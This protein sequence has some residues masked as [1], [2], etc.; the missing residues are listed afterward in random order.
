MQH[1]TNYSRSGAESADHSPG[2]GV[3][4][5]ELLDDSVESVPPIADVDERSKFR[6]RLTTIASNG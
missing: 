2:T 4:T 3:E 5:P 1:E 6:R